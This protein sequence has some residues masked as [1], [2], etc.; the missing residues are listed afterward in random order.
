[1]ATNLIT[2]INLLKANTSGNAEEDFEYLRG[3]VPG[4]R[5]RHESADVDA[6][7]NAMDSPEGRRVILTAD[8]NRA[9]FNI[10]LTQQCNGVVLEY[11]SWNVLVMPP[12]MFNPK[13]TI[14]KLFRRL[15]TYSVFE[16]NDGSIITLYWY[17]S[18]WCFASANGYEI[19]DFTWLS[20]LTYEAAVGHVFSKCG[21]S[22]DGL[23]KAHCYTI[24]FR[25]HQFHPLL[26]DAEKVWFV[27]SCDLAAINSEDPRIVI[28]YT[29]GTLQGQRAVNQSSNAL[30]KRNIESLD[31]YLQSIKGKDA[32]AEIH[33]GF[34]F[35]GNFAE[36]GPLANVM[37]EGVLLKKIRQF[38]YN[39]PKT[40]KIGPS[41]ANRLNYMVLKSYLSYSSKY[42]FLSL[43][44]QFSDQYDEYN[45]L[46]STLV[47]KIFSA[48]RNKHV[49]N[50]LMCKFENQDGVS[51]VDKLAMTFVRHIE[52]NDKIDASNVN[53]SAI[54]LD[55]IM[56]PMYIDIYCSCLLCP[57]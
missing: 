57:V 35:R 30:I 55:Y 45:E 22:T 15:A 33:Y 50:T 52:T 38:I 6:A 24:G 46:F 1:M 8:R 2:L 20:E 29:F 19:N 4:I 18:H 21:F 31:R 56:D 48:L 27:Q 10:E 5:V 34:I 32:V 7:A 17:N 43:F 13:F 28:N 16:I 26:T 3:L 51:A 23:D 14:S 36:H 9:D 49:K 47:N 12:P 40:G 41:P 54:V 11:P 25:N 53:G 42:I 37:L 39:L 44:P